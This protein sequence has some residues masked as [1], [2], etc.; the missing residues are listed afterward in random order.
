MSALKEIN[1]IMEYLEHH[2]LVHYFSLKV[3]KTWMNE[4][5]VTKTARDLFH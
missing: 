2:P 1:K 4:K 3:I 5:K